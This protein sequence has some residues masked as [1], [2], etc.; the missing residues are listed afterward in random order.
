[1]II[2]RQT[3][4]NTVSVVIQLTVLVTGGPTPLPHAPFP[5]P[6]P[7]NA[8]SVIKS[9]PRRKKALSPLLTLTKSSIH[10]PITHYPRGQY[11]QV[12]RTRSILQFY[13]IARSIISAVQPSPALSAILKTGSLRE[14][15]TGDLW[16]LCS[17]NNT[18]PTES[19]LDA[20]I[21]EC[22]VLCQGSAWLSVAQSMESVLLQY[23]RTF[24][25]N[26]GCFNT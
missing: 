22:S 3:L 5:R 16:S 18:V 4:F 2:F 24:R 11:H 26:F 8:L 14:G 6:T 13:I 7:L 10:Q 19:T 21:P 15:C 17:C 20:L 1:M 9:N 25:E 23:Y 12:V